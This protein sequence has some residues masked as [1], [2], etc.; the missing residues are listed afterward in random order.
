LVSDHTHPHDHPEAHP[1]KETPGEAPE[2]SDVSGCLHLTA[3]AT[4]HSHTHAVGTAP[5]LQSN[6][7][8]RRTK[9]SASPR[10][11]ASG[12]RELRYLSRWAMD[13]PAFRDGVDWPANATD[14]LA[15]IVLLL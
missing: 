1:Q 7:S 12:T 14:L 11:L 8:F 4:G 15:S 2:K 6:N 9:L 13:L 10:F 3:G 5:D